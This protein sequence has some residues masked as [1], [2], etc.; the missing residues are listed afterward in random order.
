MPADAP[1][2]FQNPF[3]HPDWIAVTDEQAASKTLP[4]PDCGSGPIDD[5]LLSHVPPGEA[6][7][8]TLALP[9]PEDT[10]GIHLVSF[11]EALFSVPLTAP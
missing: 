6:V 1:E 11:G 4:M 8:A 10:A 5:L 7:A 2:D 3:Q 9:V